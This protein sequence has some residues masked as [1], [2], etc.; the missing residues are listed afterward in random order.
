M[1]DLDSI[2]DIIKAHVKLGD[3]LKQDHHIYGGQNEEQFSCPFHGAD[4]KKSSRYYAETDS[5]YCWV[6]L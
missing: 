5:A 1:K 4:K 2:K 3:L 6:C